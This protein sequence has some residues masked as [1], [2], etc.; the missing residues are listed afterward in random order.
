[1]PANS[2][3][4]RQKRFLGCF[5]V[6][7]LEQFLRQDQSLVYWAL[8]GLSLLHYALTILQPLSKLDGFWVCLSFCHLGR[9]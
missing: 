7:K 5:F 3:K 4:T 2:D 1:M 8:T 6:S 9:H